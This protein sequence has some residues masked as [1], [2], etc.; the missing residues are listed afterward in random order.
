M[1]ARKREGQRDAPFLYALDKA[2]QN[3]AAK[4]DELKDPVKRL[5]RLRDQSQTM[6]RMASQVMASP[7]TSKEA[8]AYVNQLIDNNRQDRALMQRGNA[9]YKKVTLYVLDKDGNHTGETIEE[10]LHVAEAQKYNEAVKKGGA[11]PYGTRQVTVVAPKKIDRGT[12]KRIWMHNPKDGTKTRVYISEEEDYIGAGYKRGVPMSSKTALTVNQA[13]KDVNSRIEDGEFG[14]M[15]EKMSGHAASYLKKKL[16][17]NVDAT[18]AHTDTIEWLKGFDATD[19]QLSTVVEA[20]EDERESLDRI[21]PFNKEGYDEAVER[22][23]SVEEEYA[24]WREDPVAYT[25]T[26]DFRL[27]RPRYAKALEEAGHPATESNITIMYIN[28]KS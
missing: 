5:Q 1:E 8:M 28:N 23:Q 16:G 19:K 14:S 6:Q 3:L 20:L 2:K 15:A 18:Q 9:N 27:M 13:M 4:Q 24:K 22:L 25:N 11:I 12:E 21:G 10:Y 17:K 7:Y 26:D